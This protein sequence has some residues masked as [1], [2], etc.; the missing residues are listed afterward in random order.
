MTSSFRRLVLGLL[1][2]ACPALESFAQCGLEATAGD[3]LAYVQGQVKAVTNW[4]PDGA[5]PLP[6]H[7]VAVGA[8][9]VGFQ[10]D[11]GVALWNGTTWTT[12]NTPFA[13]AIVCTVWN[14]RLV[15]AAG[16][17]AFGLS[18]RSWSYDG[19]L[20]SLLGSVYLLGPV[21]PGGA[22]A[23][24]VWN[25]ELVVVGNFTGV[26]PPVGAPVAANQVAK[27]N[28]TAWSALGAG[29][30]LPPT[31]LSMLSTSVV[32][33]NNVLWVGLQYS[34]LGSPLPLVT[35]GIQVW[36][37]SSWVT[38]ATCDGAVQALA[39]RIGT[40]LT[41]SFVFAGGAFTSINSVPAQ[42]AACYSP[43]SNSWTAL[44][45]PPSF[46]IVSSVQQ[47]F[48]RAVGLNSYE[49]AASFV[50]TTA[51]KAWVWTGI[52]WSALPVLSDDAG[53]VGRASLGFFGGRYIAGIECFGIEPRRGLR[54]Y[55]EAL[56]KWP[57]L[58]GNGIGGIVE[59]VC[60][61]G[62][63]LVIGGDFTT[64]SGA[65]VN[66][67]ARGSAH[68]WQPL[69]PGFGDGHVSA[70]VRLPNG[71]FVAG[72]S[73]TMLGDGT[74]VNGIAR[75]NGLAWSPLG[76]GVDGVVRALLAMP[77]GDVIAGGTFTTAGAQA[78]SRVARWNGTTWSP[79]GAGCFGT[80]DA[81][82]RTA[83]GDVIAGGLFLAAGGQPANHVARWDGSG[84]SPLG[85][86]LDGDVW[87]LQAGPSGI[88][89]GGEFLS[90]NGVPTKYVAR[91]DGASWQP[92]AIEPNRS[93][94]ALA[95]LPAGEIVIGGT[96][97]TMA[98]DTTCAAV[99]RGSSWV[100]L[101][102]VGERAWALH[103]GAEDLAVA[104][105]FVQVGTVIA[106]NVMALRPTCP[107]SVGNAAAGCP[108]SGGANTLAAVTL[109]WVDTTFRTRAV[110][111]PANAFVLVLTSPSYVAPGVPLSLLFSQGGPGCSVLVVPDILQV[112]PAIGGTAANELF[113]PNSPSL[114]GTWFYQQMLPFELD[115]QGAW[116]AITATNSIEVVPGAF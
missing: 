23:M 17:G 15:V 69:G 28:G 95:T 2:V 49:L 97:F 41:N 12:V 26:D 107:A 7:L 81:L 89:A 55:D 66:R 84:W 38:A 93:V 29:P 58:C 42:F 45:A 114:V 20:W 106:A 34:A 43:S 4:D 74:P 53:S 6:V 25:G 67:I 32:V 91:F 76:S 50:T 62:Q 99:W 22:N 36:N 82:V 113:L 75:W 31:A 94:R 21:V 77:N 109:P 60:H 19:A 63:A 112:V 10:R 70:V 65:S 47:L 73:F 92:F 78:A 56:A 46:G 101:G 8:F 96:G 100:S 79:L 103:V 51:D 16:D 116:I 68:N 9:D 18:N 64:I 71:D 37:G 57:P 98:G 14:G 61:D 85:A 86:G 5:G 105:D 11:Q 27:W 108:S 88:V 52:A 44:G 104:G 40:A 54:A 39:T 48:V 111:V 30:T 83:N 59:A 35:G 33:F 90:S 80:V 3:P 72:G 110:G 102:V 115:A 13:S 24:T 1:V 87:A